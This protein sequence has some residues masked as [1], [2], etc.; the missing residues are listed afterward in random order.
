LGGGPDLA[1]DEKTKQWK[2]LPA[3]DSIAKIF[4]APTYPKGEMIY[5]TYQNVATTDAVYQ[6][7]TGDEWVKVPTQ[8]KHAGGAAV[9]LGGGMFVVGGIN[10]D[11]ASAEFC[12]F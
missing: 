2:P 3:D 10:E 7:A 6:R 5:A 8:K 4:K 1:Y 9:V 12:T 11:A